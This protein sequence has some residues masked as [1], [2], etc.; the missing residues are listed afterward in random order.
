MI[1]RKED[2]EYKFSHKG[3]IYY[4][5]NSGNFFKQ[6][7]SALNYGSGKMKIQV[8]PSIELESYFKQSLLNYER[9]LKLKRILKKNDEKK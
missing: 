7:L 2:N 1:I 8:I 9:E 6:E 4:R 3:D 5:S